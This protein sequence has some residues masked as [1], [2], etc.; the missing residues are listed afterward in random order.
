MRWSILFFLVFSALT[1]AAQVSSTGPQ[2]FYEGQPVT[3]IDL[4][5]NPHRDVEPLRAL[6]AQQSGEPYSQAKVLASIDALQEKG[7]FEKVTVNVVPEVSGL[8]LNFILEPAY[9]LGIIDFPGVTKF[10]SYTRLLQT[11]NLQ[12]EDPYDEARIPVAK[13]ALLHF[14][15]H[16]GY[17]L[18]KVDFAVQIDDV[19]QLVNITFST[20]MGKQARIGSVN[21]HG[22]PD[23]EQTTLLHKTRTLRAT[24]HGGVAQAGKTLHSGAHPGCNQTD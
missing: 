12:D 21:L 1:L 13:A 19:H 24:I 2:A 5:A 3:A 14:L 16:N 22:P 20:A 9:Y 11:V 10:F 4:I 15:Q 18:A 23:S 17:F 8:R 7:G 6:V